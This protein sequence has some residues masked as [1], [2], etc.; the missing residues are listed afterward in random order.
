MSLIERLHTAE[1]QSRE[2]AREGFS[3]ALTSLEE[4]QSRLRRRM[5]LHP[6]AGKP[7]SAKARQAA[8]P[9][10][11]INGRDLPPE[12]LRTQELGN[13]EHAV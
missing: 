9:I 7:V 10:V 12:N 1:H 5:R 4:A 6:R 13:K 3:R 2:A 8:M 11:T